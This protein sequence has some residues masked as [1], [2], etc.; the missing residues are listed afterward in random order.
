MII[1]DDSLDA[2]FIEALY[3]KYHVTQDEA[4]S[5]L[6]LAKLYADNVDK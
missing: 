1:P 4:I 2:Q 6:I 5:I 3:T